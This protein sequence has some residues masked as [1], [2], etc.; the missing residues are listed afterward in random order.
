[1][2][3]IFLLINLLRNL[4]IQ[5]C[6][7]ITGNVV[8]MR[9]KEQA[10]LRQINAILNENAKSLSDYP[11]LPQVDEYVLPDVTN[12]LVMQ[13][14]SYDQQE[15]ASRSRDLISKLNCEQKVIFDKI[16]HAVDCDEGGFFFV[17]GFG[18]TDKTFL[19]NS[20]AATLRADGK[21]VVAVSSSGIAATL[22]PS[23]STAH[24]R[25]AIPIEVNEASTCSIGQIL[26]LAELLR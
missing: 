12:R 19:W 4:A 8:S 7:L 26:P 16:M 11:S 1:M 24:S 3:C 22:L 2:Q 23:G 9:D 5:C 17:H 13:E 15:Q 10:A 21:I 14:T 25:F 20:L 18:G 6:Q